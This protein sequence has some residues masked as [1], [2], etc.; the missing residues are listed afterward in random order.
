MS[1]KNRRVAHIAKV[2][3]RKVIVIIMLEEYEL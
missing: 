2:Y 1:L 3:N